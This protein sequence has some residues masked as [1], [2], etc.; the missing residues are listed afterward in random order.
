[1]IGETVFFI[2]VQFALWGSVTT[3]ATGGE[4]RDPKINTGISDVSLAYRNKVFKVSKTS[5]ATGSANSYYERCLITAA[6]V[7]QG[8]EPG[9]FIF[10]NPPGLHEH[11][12]VVR[13]TAW[14]V[15]GDKDIGFIW[16]TGLTGILRI[17]EWDWTPSDYATTPLAPTKVVHL[18]GFGEDGAGGAG[19]RRW[20]ISEMYGSQAFPHPD[21]QTG[22]YFVR[23]KSPF[24]YIGCQGDSGGPMLHNGKIYGVFS[25]GSAAPCN[26]ITQ[27]IY[28]STS[29][30]A[31][32][33]HKLPYLYSRACYKTLVTNAFNPNLDAC[34]DC[35]EV[36]GS[37][38]GIGHRD[39]IYDSGDDD[40]DENVN[41]DPDDPN[42]GDCEENIVQMD[43]E[44]MT[45]TASPDNGCSFVRWDKR[46][47]YCPCHGSLV[48][49]C[50]LNFNNIG[51]YDEM[52]SVDGAECFAVFDCVKEDMSF[53]EGGEEE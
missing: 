12:M 18:V 35:G 2:I 44:T 52:T 40:W 4:H 16:V 50:T 19:K 46:T 53:E 33:N 10:N 17:S 9:N 43:N 5:G 21:G 25:M 49:T 41:C 1:M 28:T 24:N 27:N 37:M 11:Q 29:H 34:S 23:K 8:T 48:S 22:S 38:S 15:A 47:G 39:P 32:V 45:L 26:Q 3:K 13:T 20:G 14:S 42:E 30:S 36:V 7:A 31:V 6:H 51:Y